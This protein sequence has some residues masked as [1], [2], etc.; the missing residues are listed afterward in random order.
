MRCQCDW[1]SWQSERAGACGL[2]G[3]LEGEAGGMG[4]KLS[5]NVD[6]GQ[7][8]SL[9]LLCTNDLRSSAAQRKKNQSPICFTWRNP[10]NQ[11]LLFFHQI[12]RNLPPALSLW[13]ISTAAE[14]PSSVIISM[15]WSTRNG[16]NL[17]HIPWLKSSSDYPVGDALIKSGRS[18]GFRREARRLDT[19]ARTHVTLS[20]ILQ[21]GSR[22]TF[23]SRLLGWKL[24]ES[25]REYEILVTPKPAR[26]RGVKLGRRAI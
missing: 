26:K 7:T 1:E 4:G 20:Y 14:N 12:P 3:K 13:W 8:A 22:Q 25:L 18:G 16:I 21:M 9:R 5:P 19:F 23:S 10:D 24:K 6:S 17:Q 2:A 11:R 15:H